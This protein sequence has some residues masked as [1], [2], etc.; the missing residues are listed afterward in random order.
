MKPPEEAREPETWHPSDV[1]QDVQ[2]AEE[3]GAASPFTCPECSGTLWETGN[4][5]DLIRFQ[6]RVGHA[7]SPRSMLAEQGHSLERALWVALRMM[8]ENVAIS[9]RIVSH[10]SERGRTLLAKHFAERA[11]EVEEHASTL[12]AVLLSFPPEEQPESDSP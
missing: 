10:A 11:R 3:R 4:G 12:K 6:C 8:E 7:Y 2:A 9:R 5:G 1:L